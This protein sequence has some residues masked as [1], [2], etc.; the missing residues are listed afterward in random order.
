[1]KCTTIIDV[2]REDEVII[3]SHARTALVEEIEA[4]ATKGSST[5][6]GYGDGHIVTI[7]ANELHAVTVEDGK[8]YALTA[9]GKYDLRRRLYEVEAILEPH[10]VRINQSCIGNVRCIARFDVSIG[11]ALMV[12][13]K[14]GYKDYVSRRQLKHVKERLG[15]KR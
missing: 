2:C 15:I 3:Y 8:T 13:F 12:T 10:F 11:G 1:M 6:V 5:L 14:N 7:A 9:G 4:L